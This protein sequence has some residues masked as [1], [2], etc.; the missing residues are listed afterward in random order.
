[1]NQYYHN[2]FL[3]T[4]IRLLNVRLGREVNGEVGVYNG[5]MSTNCAAYV[6]TTITITNILM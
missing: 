2:T 5:E 3:P 4:P 1:M 6:I